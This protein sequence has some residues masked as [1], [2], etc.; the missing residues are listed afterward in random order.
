MRPI[1][2]SSSECTRR[3]SRVLL[4]SSTTPELCRLAEVSATKS[5]VIMCAAAWSAESDVGGVGGRAVHVCHR[6]LRRKHAVR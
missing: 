2:S 1:S 4:S 5:S 6:V 3:C